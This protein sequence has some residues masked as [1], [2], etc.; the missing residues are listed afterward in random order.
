MEKDN[1]L[2]LSRVEQ[3]T[4]QNES[5]LSKKI[6]HRNFQGSILFQKKKRKRR[7]Y[8]GMRVRN[9]F[10]KHSLSKRPI[11]FGIHPEGIHL[12]RLAIF[13]SENGCGICKIYIEKNLF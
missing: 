5:S 13:Y 7:P 9:F 3:F 12:L 4:S 10:I 11:E 1:A 8:V 2:L 6:E